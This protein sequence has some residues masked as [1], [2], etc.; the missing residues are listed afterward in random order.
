MPLK[1]SVTEL[2]KLVDQQASMALM[3]VRE[4]GEY[5]NAHI[6]NSHTVPRPQLERRMPALVTFRGTLI[7]VYD[8]DERRA[9]LAAATLK[10]MGYD[11]VSVL[12]GGINRWA[13]EGQ[14]TEWG[15]YVQRRDFGARV[16]VEQK[17]PEMDAK[18]LHDRLGSGEEIVILDTR[19][20][21][22]HQK[23]CIPG[24]RCVPEGEL[25]LRIREIADDPEKTVVLHCAGWTRAYLGAS[26]LQRMGRKRVYA[27]RNGTMG[28]LMAGLELEKGSQRIGLPDP[29]REGLAAAQAFAATIAREDGVQYLDIKEL[30]ELM[31]RA[32]QQNVY[33]IDV[34]SRG[35]FVQGHVPG[36]QWFPGGQAVVLGDDVVILKDA[37]VVFC[38][39]GRVRASVTAS[40][41]R[42][43][44]FPN[45][46][47][48]DGGT[49]AWAAAGH[50]LE[51]GF[52]EVMPFGYSGAMEKVELIS[53]LELS[54]LTSGP[55]SP[56]VIFVDTSQDFSSGHVPGARWMPRGWLEMRIHEMA[57]LKDSDIIITCSDGIN[58]VLAGATL[59]GLD[60]RKVSVLEGGMRAWCDAGLPVEKGL[61]GILSP[62]E[63]VVYTDID[64][65][66]AE[67]IKVL[68]WEEQMGTRYQAAPTETIR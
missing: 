52:P 18:E 25:A 41:H 16:R 23:S 62:P 17:V 8:D 43:M 26:A 32:N 30:R 56:D 54:T 34:R 68:Q 14:P 20:P 3:D 47:A 7:I 22:E 53:P 63:D 65:N 28:W 44:G 29:S 6:P 33:L 48:V 35:E 59:R 42:Q 38:C 64:R 19:T 10:L 57:P 15:T 2:K 61:T 40:W 13:S 27:L 51:Q 31:A 1:I 36:F 39:D 66:W 46:F 12:E 50:T 5:Y 60:Y 24:S 49:S 55:Y 4:R 21:E 9:S 37:T 11:N 67:T 45:V 58:S